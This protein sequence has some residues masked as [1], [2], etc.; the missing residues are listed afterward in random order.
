MQDRD[1]F[2]NDCYL[3][4]CRCQSCPITP[5]GCLVLYEAGCMLPNV[6]PCLGV[7]RRR[8][9]WKRDRVI[10]QKS[11][12][13]SLL[14]EAA[15]LVAVML[16]VD[17]SRC[18][19]LSKGSEYRLVKVQE[20]WSKEAGCGGF[21]RPTLPSSFIHHRQLPSTPPSISNLSSHLLRDANLTQGCT[22]QWP[23]G[24]NPG[25]TAMAYTSAR[26]RR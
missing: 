12:P 14:L 17:R 25:F 18:T 20:A 23:S 11:I 10:C 5:R 6:V 15:L 16:S 2:R 8:P 7:L 21:H 13:E 22:M 9:Y 4:L 24:Y 19:R 1:Y 3:R 26:P